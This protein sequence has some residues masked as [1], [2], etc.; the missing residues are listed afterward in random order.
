MD[1]FHLSMSFFWWWNH[2]SRI[3][4][5]NGHLIQSRHKV[6]AGS[7]A[8]LL[9]WN[10]SWFATCNALGLEVWAVGVS[11]NGPDWSCKVV[12]ALSNLPM[13]S[14]SQGH[15]LDNILKHRHV[16]RKPAQVKWGLWKLRM[17]WK[18]FKDF[19]PK[20]FRGGKKSTWTLKL[21]L[22]ETPT[23]LWSRITCKNT[24]HK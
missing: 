9:L 6:L 22:F 18:T 5:F 3:S 15:E 7:S 17:R 12:Q 24:S 8:S 16:A 21:A 10:H 14:I 19:Q 11:C 1:F 4:N 23:S 2:G 13:A 20:V